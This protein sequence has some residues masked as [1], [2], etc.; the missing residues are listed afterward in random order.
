MFRTTTAITALSLLALS[1]VAGCDKS[2]D[3]KAEE[4]A[5]AQRTAN[6][7]SVE[8]QN[9][10]NDKANKAQIEAN[11]TIVKEQNKAA[12]KADDLNKDLAVK[13]EDLRKSLEKDLASVDK[14]VIDLRTKVSTAKNTKA[15]KA[16]LEAAIKDIQGQSDALKKSISN[17]AATTADS[18]AATKTNLETQ[19]SALAKSL[20]DIE[21]K[22]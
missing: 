20:D 1:T 9:E 15:P 13:R 6:Q 11:D 14:R 8:A 19:V 22:V 10:A 21:K 12:A 5:E 18:F 16:E 17:V 4:V 7:R 3:K 2:A